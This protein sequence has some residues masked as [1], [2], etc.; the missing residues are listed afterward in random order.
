MIYFD[1]ADD[2]VMLTLHNV[3]LSSQ[4][5]CQHNNKCD[6]SKTNSYKRS[7]NYDF[8]IKYCYSDILL[9]NT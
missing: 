3:T 4:K 9:K 6:C 8:S 2:N 7:L 1:K 5:P